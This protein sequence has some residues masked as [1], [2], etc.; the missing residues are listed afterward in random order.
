[1]APPLHI[2]RAHAQNGQVGNS[3]L[4]TLHICRGSSLGQAAELSRIVSVQVVTQVNP[5]SES[6]GGLGVQKTQNPPDFYVRLND[7]RSLNISPRLGKPLIR[8]VV[9]FSYFE[10]E[11]VSGLVPALAANFFERSLHLGRS[12]LPTLMPR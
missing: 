9:S 6:E 11:P 3:L 12:F 10:D 1:M 8:P 2:N 4:L 5:G 7:A